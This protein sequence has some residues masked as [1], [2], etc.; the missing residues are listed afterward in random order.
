MKREK[1]TGAKME[2]STNPLIITAKGIGFYKDYGCRAESE[3]V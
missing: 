2:Y 3:V 1:R